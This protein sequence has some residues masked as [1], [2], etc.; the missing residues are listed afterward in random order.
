ML[1]AAN[2]DGIEIDGETVLIDPGR[3]LAA[4]GVTVRA[5]LTAV[6]CQPGGAVVEA[7]PP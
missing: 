3:L 5:N 2:Q 1:A 7:G 4:E 6:R